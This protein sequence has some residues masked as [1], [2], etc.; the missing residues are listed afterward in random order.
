MS[1]WQIGESGTEVKLDEQGRAQVTFTVTNTGTAQ[2]R[3]VLTI[4]AL[5][6]AAESWFTVEEPQRAVPAGQSAAYLCNV[7]VDAAV[8]PATYAMQAV[9]Y[10]ADR[11]PGETSATSR[12]VTIVKEQPAKPPPS[13]PWWAFVV[14][15]VIMLIVIAV[16]AF[17]VFGGDDGLGNEELPAIS[18][19]PEVAAVLTA[20]PGVWSAPEEDLEFTFQWLRCDADGEECEPIEGAISPQYPVG[21]D[22]LAATLRVEVEASDGDSSGDARSEPTPAIAPTTIQPQPVPNVVGMTRSAARALLSPP[23]Q[24]GFLDA[25]P[26]A[27]N[28]DPEVS[29]QTP[30]P[31]T[32][33]EPGAQ[34]ILSSQPPGGANIF[35]FVRID[36]SLVFGEAQVFT[37]EDFTGL[38]TTTTAP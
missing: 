25:G 33:L 13:T 2:D 8:A 20:A 28:C 15:A 38:P 6:G 7:L 37:A 27:G 19:T 4:T 30:D 18:G 32:L 36:P 5:D 3:S 1:T 16:I 22:D 17:F 29:D 34:V 12:R 26:L 14:V 11:D 10:S 35:C 23:F 9:V 31:G 24:V 21:A